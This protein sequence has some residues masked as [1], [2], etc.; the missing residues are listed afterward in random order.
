MG[1]ELLG[2]KLGMTQLFNDDGDR[3]PVTVI[4]AVPSVVVQKKGADSDGYSAVQLGFEERKEKHSSKAALGHFARAGV[5]PR[6]VLYEVR[7]PAE[8]VEGLDLGQELSLA[9]A[10]PEVAKVDITGTSKGR[11]FS[12]VIRRWGFGRSKSTHGTHEFFRHGGAMGAGTYPG[13]I[14]KGKK[15]AGQHGNRLVTQLGL[16]LEK[17]DPDKHLLF[18]RRRARPPQRARA[19][20]GVD[21][22]APRPATT[23]RTSSIGELR[24]RAIG[25]APPTSCATC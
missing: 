17:L 10:F 25:R 12:G 18:V 9:D 20:S 5:S 11:G 14:P 19:D 1:M 23:A 4:Q 24:T 3:I 21:S 6:R 15:M 13:R 8:Q 16:T 2:R 7:L 22:L